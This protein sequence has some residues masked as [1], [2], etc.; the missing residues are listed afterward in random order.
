MKISFSVWVCVDL[1]TVRRVSSC[2]TL[3]YHMFS[4]CR[5]CSVAYEG[6]GFHERTDTILTP[7]INLKTLHFRAS[8][9]IYF[10]SSLLGS[11]GGPPR[12]VLVG[13][14]FMCAIW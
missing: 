4:L 8:F 10:G 14:H 9:A 5:K 1:G 2:H 11:L 7:F 13:C 3:K 12:A 6:F